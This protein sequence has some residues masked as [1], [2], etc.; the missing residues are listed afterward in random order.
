MEGVLVS[1]CEADGR[2]G[3]AVGIGQAAGEHLLVEEGTT[4]AV[5]DRDDQLHGE[6]PDDFGKLETAALCD[7]R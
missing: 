3:R 1:E 4:D 2:L 5:V 7:L 6:R